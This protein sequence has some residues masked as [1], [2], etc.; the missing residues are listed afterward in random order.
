MINVFRV[1]IAICFVL[2]CQQSLLA[3]TTIK[4]RGDNLRYD[5]IFFDT[6]EYAFMFSKNDLEHSH[7]ISIAFL[8]DYLVSLL[9]V[10]ANLPDSTVK[11]YEFKTDSMTNKVMVTVNVANHAE[12]SLI[13]P[14]GSLIDSSKCLKL[15]SVLFCEFDK[16]QIGIWR[17]KIKGSGLFVVYVTGSSPLS[18][19]DFKFVEFDEQARHGGFFEIKGSP[20]VGKKYALKAILSEVMPNANIRM[21]F[22]SKERKI[23][24]SFTV[25]NVDNYSSETVFLRENVEIPSEAFFVRVSGK[26]KNGVEFERVY[27]YR[28]IPSTLSVVSSASGDLPLDA[29]T[30]YTFRVTNHS[31]EDIVNFSVVDDK[32][33]VIG[34]KPTSAVIKKGETTDIKV[35]LRPSQNVAAGTKSTLTF[36][37]TAKSDVKLASYIF[38]E[39]VASKAK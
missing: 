31:K 38:V 15:S 4:L 10:K 18:F 13:Q 35:I 30:T 7:K 37:A 28:T 21:E 14:D 27:P 34:V 22:Y 32:G 25:D 23:L 9:N 26:D 2:I 29:D 17:I 33:F 39:C 11:S 20:I 5:Q 16:P 12:V 8:D 3:D 36:A 6:S 1:A 19:I 24:D